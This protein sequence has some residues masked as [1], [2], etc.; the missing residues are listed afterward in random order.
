MKLKSKNNRHLTIL[1][2]LFLASIYIINFNNFASKPNKVIKN[3]VKDE[4]IYSTLKTSLVEDWS[5]TWSEGVNEQGEGIA[6][7]NSTGDIYVTGY[8]DDIDG[9]VIL[10]KYNSNGIQQWNVTWDN[11]KDELGY[12]VA[13]DSQGFVYVAGSNGTFPGSSSDVLLLKFNSTG[14]QEWVRTW[15][16]GENDAG[17]ALKIDSQDNIYIAGRTKTLEADL[18]LL[19]YDSSGVYKWNSTFGGPNGQ[20]GFDIALDSSNNIYVAGLDGPNPDFDLL[21]VKFNSSGSHEWNMTWG[22]TGNDQGFGVALDSGNGVYITGKTT[23][24]G[25]LNDDMVVVKYDTAGNWQWNRTWGTS[26]T[27][28]AKS[29]GVDSADNIYMYGFTKFA[30][31]SIVKYSTS[32]EFLWDKQWGNTPTYAYWG[33]DLF[34]DSFDKIYITGKNRTGGI[35]IYDIFV[36]KLSIEA[37]GNFTLS[38]NAGS[39][40]DDGAFTLTWT[41]SSGANNYSIYQHSSYI[42]DINGSL[43]ILA[44]ETN[45]LSLPLSGFSNGSY[46][47]IAVAF[48]NFGERTSNSINIV[49]GIPPPPP[50]PSSFTLSS[51][52]GSPDDDGAFTL[53]WT[54]S[55]GANNYSIYQYSS[56]ITAIN[57]SLTLLASET[58]SL[59]QPTIGYSDGTYFFIVVA[60]NDSGN[61][62]SN[63]LIIIVELTVDTST[64]PGTPGIPGFNLMIVGLV[65]GI[66][67]VILIK[68]KSKLK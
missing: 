20:Y 49:V 42:T 39:P 41:S 68:K 21:L 51:N 25:A 30:N 37:P 36:T 4:D 18:L 43:T 1:I 50:P 31:V 27:D 7:D 57:G 15:D 63:V 35:G 44:T 64:T 59:S 47:F 28:E 11:G 46:Y 17:W 29:I 55:S 53:T 65:I 3:E 32:G 10:I 60:F 52:A 40:D 12:D 19:K 2:L 9:D 45:S 26:F 24:Y 58:N 38:S 16:S 6:V 14:E 61:K 13:V 48:N 5:V 56:F 54:S 34:L 66:V 22:G 67:S 23:S 8:I 62:T 33:H